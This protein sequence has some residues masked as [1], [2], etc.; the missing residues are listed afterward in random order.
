MGKLKRIYLLSKLKAGK[1]EYFDE[2][3]ELTKGAV[4]YVVRKYVRQDFFAEDV[5]QDVYVSFLNNMQNV[6]GD[7]L[8]YLCGM[9]K[10]RAL[11][12][13][14]KDAKVD[15]NQLPEDLPFA[16]ADEY[17]TDNVLLQTCKKRLSEEEYFI[18]EHTVVFGYTR[19]A[20]AE[21]MDKPISTVNRKYN[22]ILKKVKILAKEVYR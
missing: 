12:S 17:E 10:N 18:L 14:K 19:V 13:I 16:T 21:M 9:A 20:V 7:P 8:P 6:V 2:F 3:Y 1:R 22:D 5:M 15:K 11:D 4:W